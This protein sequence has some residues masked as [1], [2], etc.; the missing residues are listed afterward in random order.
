MYGPPPLSGQHCGS[1]SLV[2]AGRGPADGILD[3]CDERQ[4]LGGG[5]EA[6]RQEDSD[7]KQRP[8]A[9]NVDTIIT[10]VVNT[11]PTR[12]ICSR[13]IK[14]KQGA[15][16]C[17]S[18]GHLV[19]P[20]AAADVCV[21][22]VAEKVGSSVALNTL[23][24]DARLEQPAAASSALSTNCEP[25]SG[26]PTQRQHAIEREG[27]AA[28][29]LELLYLHVE[30]LEHSNSLAS[31]LDVQSEPTPGS[32]SIAVSSK[33]SAMMGGDIEVEEAAPAP[34]LLLAPDGLQFGA[35]SQCGSADGKEWPVAELAVEPML[36]ASKDRVRS[37]G[38]KRRLGSD[39]SH[40][41]SPLVQER[42]FQVRFG[43][44]SMF[45]PL[46]VSVQP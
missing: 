45:G 1:S 31:R 41:G 15:A 38:M 42:H 10:A 9:E 28:E 43:D 18:R 36:R 20:V 3:A 44:I 5:G 39:E 12:R 30:G 27:R 26:Q 22:G 23:N 14:Q 6:V 13:C 40:S 32:T 29:G 21:T 2:P 24:P 46:W 25:H 4:A 17:K 11:L 19:P 8:R 35:V 33:G 34:P 37:V 16:F 7:N